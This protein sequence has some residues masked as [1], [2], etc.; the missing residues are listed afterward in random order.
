[1]I[2]YIIGKPRSR[3]ELEA[4]WNHDEIVFVDSVEE[5]QAH[6]DAH[7]INGKKPTMVIVDELEPLPR[8]NVGSIGHV[9]RGK[10]ALSA[11]LANLDFSEIELRVAATIER[12]E[13]VDPMMDPKGFQ[14]LVD[15]ITMPEPMPV[16]DTHQRR[17]KGDKHRNRRFRWS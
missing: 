6:R 10:Y 12:G 2:V 17:S 9:D 13:I 7:M 3:E 1:M 15:R 5:Y 14:K 4:I 11:A 8:V 16:I